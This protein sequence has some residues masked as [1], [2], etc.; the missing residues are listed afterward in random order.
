MTHTPDTPARRIRRF[1]GLSLDDPRIPVDRRTVRALEKSVASRIKFPNLIQ[2]AL[3]YGCPVE[4]LLGVMPLPAGL[5]HLRP[6]ET[7]LPSHPPDTMAWADAYH[8][9]LL[10]LLARFP[11]VIR[12][13]RQRL[14][15]SQ[16]GAARLVGFNQVSLSHYERGHSMPTASRLA[17]MMRACFFGDSHLLALLGVHPRVYG[18]LQAEVSRVMD[19]LASAREGA[20]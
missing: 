11:Q 13:A 2:L 20:Q 1:Y 14:E 12:E 7:S 3:F 15:L 4:M 9:R 10:D 16:D 17:Q 5:D 6:G 8:Q 18:R 19:L